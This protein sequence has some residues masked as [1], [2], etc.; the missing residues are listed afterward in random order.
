MLESVKRSSLFKPKPNLFNK[1]VY[2]VGQRAAAWKEMSLWRHNILP[3]DTHPN[4]IHYND[5]EHNDTV[6]ASLA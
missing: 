4:A 5:A 3:N 2:D 1:N 6:Q